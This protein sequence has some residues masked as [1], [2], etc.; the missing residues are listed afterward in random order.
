MINPPPERPIITSVNSS[1]R[2][3]KAQTGEEY[4]THQL[5]FFFGSK[6]KYILILCAID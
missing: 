5:L 1:Y 2:G 4:G 6:S 3:L